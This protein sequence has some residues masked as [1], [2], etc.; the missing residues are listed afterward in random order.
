MHADA[1]RSG[2]TVDR[3]SWHAAQRPRRSSPRQPTH[4]TGRRRG[5]ITSTAALIG[6]TAAHGVGVGSGSLNPWVSAVRSSSASIPR[7]FPPID[8]RLRSAGEIPDLTETTRS[9]GSPGWPRATRNPV[10]HAHRNE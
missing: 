8:N 10:L 7:P 6:S 1:Y 4:S 9:S 5:R 2:P 3:L